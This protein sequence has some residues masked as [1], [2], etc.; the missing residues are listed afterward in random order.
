MSAGG[1]ETGAPAGIAV[2]KEGL[3]FARMVRGR[4][5]AAVGEVMLSKADR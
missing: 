3:N 1:A 2:Q 5:C 4:R